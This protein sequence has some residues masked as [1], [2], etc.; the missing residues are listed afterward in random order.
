MEILK[1]TGTVLAVIAAGAVIFTIAFIF[2]NADNDSEPIFSVINDTN[3]SAAEA[4]CEHAYESA[5]GDVCVKC[6]YVFTPEIDS[7]SQTMY[8]VKDN[9]PVRSTYYQGDNV[10]QYLNEGEAIEISGSLLNA[11]DHLWYITED[12]CYVYGDN[13]ISKQ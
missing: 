12:G 13:L 2:R 6:G 7:F 9:C 11:L 1:K 8:S 5:T 3:T 4:D 10:T